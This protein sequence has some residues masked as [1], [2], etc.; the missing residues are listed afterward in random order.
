MADSFFIIYSYPCLLPLLNT[1]TPSGLN[2][3]MSSVPYHSLCEFICASVL[4]CLEVTVSLEL[5]IPLWLLQSFYIFHV[6][7]WVLKG[8]VW[9]RHLTQD[10]MHQRLSV[11]ILSSFRTYNF[12][13]QFIIIMA[14]SLVISRQTW[15]LIKLELAPFFQLYL[16]ELSLFKSFF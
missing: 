11:Y 16:H 15:C 13:L 4:L 2:L 3:C 7:P 8:G 6:A 9:W 5:F 10:K 1:K 14:G 12:R